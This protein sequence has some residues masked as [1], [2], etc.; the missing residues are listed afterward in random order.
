M[1]F[2]L[3]ETVESF[4]GVLSARVQ[5]VIKQ[6]YG[7]GKTANKHTLEAIGVTYGI[8]R[9]RV[10]QI[11]NFALKAMRKSEIYKRVK[12][13]FDELKKEVIS[14]GGIVNERKFLEHISP[15]KTVQNQ[16]HF[17]LILGNDFERLR[18]DEEFY[19]RWMV[20]KKLG[21]K[22]H[23]AL[24]RLCSNIKEEDLIREE[25]LVSDFLKELKEIVSESKNPELARHW[26]ELSKQLSKNPL[27]EW[28]LAKSP[29]V[30]MR[31]VRD[32]AYL[33]MRSHGEPMHFVEV[34][35]GIENT[36]KKPAH[37]AT[38]HNEL[39]KDKRFVLVGR[40]LYALAEWGYREGVVKDVIRE[41]IK[42]KGPLTKDEV[43][44]GVMKERLVKTNTVIVNLQNN[45]FFR[46][47]DSGRYM[48]L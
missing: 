6:R 32:Y 28:G 44:E 23:E 41:L 19:H 48:A 1:T 11:E 14:F 36:F 39:I 35:R 15:D 8:T 18:E 13:V 26:L 47:N 43:I 31:G 5:D 34:A 27:G 2:N 40:G 10:R 46:K 4:L 42:S 7:L 21:D 12:S 33:I 22:V 3:K 17:L 24:R 37:T 45:E 16:A 38:C 25:Q 29:N 30:R 20:D 9:E